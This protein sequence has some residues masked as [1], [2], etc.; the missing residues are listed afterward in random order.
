MMPTF[1][2]SCPHLDEVVEVG[3]YVYPMGST[4][5]AD[6]LD[7]INGFTTDNL[8]NKVYDHQLT[9]YTD[10]DTLVTEALYELYEYC[11]FIDATEITRLSP[12]HVNVR[13]TT[14]K[15]IDDDEEIEWV[16]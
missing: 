1:K 9:F 7:Y 3:A 13:F 12:T 11:E 2:P 16:N 5:D 15:P 10:F 8:G 14:A 4:A 6:N